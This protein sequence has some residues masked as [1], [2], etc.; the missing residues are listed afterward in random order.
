MKKYILIL[1]ALIC[2]S[3]LFAANGAKKAA[4]KA[5]SL[6]FN[7]KTFYLKYSA[8]TESEWL[9]EFLPKGATFT[10]YTE[11]VALRSYDSLKDA[12]PIQVAQAI[13]ANY[14]RAYPGIKFML[15][16]NEK[17]GDGLVSYIMIQGDILEYN[18]FRTT[19]KNKT[20]ISIQYVY[21]K[22]VP[23]ATRTPADLKAFSGETKQHSSTW[24]NALDALSAPD[25]V[26]DVIK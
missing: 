24:I 17:T 26:R 20:P 15:A 14:Q 3:A 10:N 7:G 18:L 1:G 4:P 5:S 25:M 2:F 23:Q 22:Y 12:T 9:N 16:G 6:V 13:A 19:L 8:G 11:M 21:R